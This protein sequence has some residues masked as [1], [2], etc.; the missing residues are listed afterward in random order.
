M[1]VLGRKNLAF[2]IVLLTGS[3]SEAG[4]NGASSEIMQES[5]P[6]GC[7]GFVQAVGGLAWLYTICAY[8]RMPL[9]PRLYGFPLRAFQVPNENA[10]R[11]EQIVQVN[12]E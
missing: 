5:K 6:I 9:P 2:Y 1:R 4:G 11:H 12:L 3:S 7:M 10:P 8:A